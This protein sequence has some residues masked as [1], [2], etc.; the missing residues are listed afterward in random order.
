VL[1][2]HYGVARMTLDRC[3][4]GVPLST[5]GGEGPFRANRGLRWLLVSVLDAILWGRT[6]PGVSNRMKS[7]QGD[8]PVVPEEEEHVDDA[9]GALGLVYSLQSGHTPAR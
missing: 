9:A 8:R 5:P 6:G 2:E 1:T 7:I 4:L 3:H